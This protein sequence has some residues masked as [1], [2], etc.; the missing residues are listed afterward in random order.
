[1]LVKVVY[2]ASLREQLG[3]AEEPITLEGSASIADLLELLVAKHGELGQRVLKERQVL[4][5]L[6]QEMCD[7]SQVMAEGDEVAFFPPVTG[8]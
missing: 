7:L 4:T 3:L 1:M 5:A 2:F 6:N 8:G